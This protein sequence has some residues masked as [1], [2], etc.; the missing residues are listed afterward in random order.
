M[1]VYVPPALCTR[2]KEYDDINWSRVA[3]AAFDTAMNQHDLMA[4]TPCIVVCGTQVLGP[5]DNYKA[6][7]SWAT[8]NL[9][10]AWEIKPMNEVSEEVE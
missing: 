4:T 5:F 10:T 3:C 7:S 1:N 9:R 8:L 6:A 2:M